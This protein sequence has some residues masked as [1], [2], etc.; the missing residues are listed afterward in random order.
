MDASAAAAAWWVSEAD[1]VLVVAGAG[2]SIGSEQPDHGRS[3]VDAA[4]FAHF[5]PGLEKYG[6]TNAYQATLGGGFN[7]APKPNAEAGWLKHGHLMAGGAKPHKGYSILLNLLKDKDYFV[8]TSNVDGLLAEAGFDKDRIYTP[9]GEFARRQCTKPCSN[10]A[11]WATRPQLEKLLPLLDDETTAMKSPLPEW[12]KKCPFCKKNDSFF[13]L[14]GGDNFIHRPY[15]AA[16]DRLVAWLEQVLQE[17]RRLV[18]L[19]IGAGFNTPVVTR[20]PAESIAREAGAPLVRINPD[21]HAVPEDLSL[22]VGL[23]LSCTEALQAISSVMASAQAAEQIA[24]A[25]SLAASG[26]DPTFRSFKHR[27]GHFDWRIFLANLQDPI[28]PDTSG[29]SIGGS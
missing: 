15:Q 18:V 14:R 29:A 6:V 3:F 25:R 4:D 2:M 19:E 10:D 20:W 11:T 17:K 27:Y 5:Y 21:H 26:S 24:K 13:N 23:A 7:R 28:R 22:A 1:A 9:Q 16:Q 8:H 12:Y